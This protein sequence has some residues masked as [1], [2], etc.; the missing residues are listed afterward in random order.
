[1]KTQTSYYLKYAGVLL[2]STLLMFSCSNGDESGA[3]P[4]PVDPIVE[5]TALVLATSA[6]EIDKGDTVT[7]DVTADDEAVDADI[8]INNDKINGTTHTFEE[9]GTYQVVAKKEGYID[10]EAVDIISYQVDVY[11]AGFDIGGAVYW[12]NGTIVPLS[13]GK[14]SGPRANGI[15]VDNGDVYVSGVDNDG[16]GNLAVYWKNGT[17]VTME[18]SSEYP[19]AYGRS[20][21]VDNGNVY[22]AGEQSAL[23]PTG[24]YYSETTY[25]KNGEPVNL[26]DNGRAVEI[27][28][29]DGDVYMIALESDYPRK[30]AN[31]WKNDAQSELNGGDYLLPTAMTVENSDVYIT[32]SKIFSNN[33][34]L[35]T[36][37]AIYWKNGTL[38]TLTER[39]Y[40]TDIAIDNGDV[41]ISATDFNAS[42]NA[43]KY[44]K[45]DEVVFLTDGKQISAETTSIAVNNGD[46][47][48]AGSYDHDPVYWKNGTLITL[49][50]VNAEASEILVVRSLGEN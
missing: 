35:G 25:W 47:Y 20:I 50:G 19:M 36:G 23:L 30:I 38:V 16:V 1:M 10:S 32:G 46:V 24:G 18:T 48:V 40:P 26:G 13:E 2:C 44:W 27:V 37:T 22:V 41:Y 29:K 31:Y 14:K 4:D 8:Y 28:V 3:E 12:K 17:R 15:V 39:T 5:K 11:V 7:F 9:A 45:N 42:R 6:T 21:A 43:A 34:S 33:G 49:E